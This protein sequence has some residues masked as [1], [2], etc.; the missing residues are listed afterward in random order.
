MNRR[1]FI[2]SS[3]TAATFFSGAVYSAATES[4]NLYNSFKTH[5]LIELRVKSFQESSQQD[6]WSYIQDF[7]I[8]DSNIYYNIED[9]V[10]QVF[11]HCKGFNYK[12]CEVK[13][14]I[15][16][17]NEKSGLTHAGHY[18][19]SDSNYIFNGKVERPYIYEGW[20]TTNP[21]SSKQFYK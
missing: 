2:K 9:A 4:L 19:F 7:W 15:L 10:S 21:S 6:E 12:K 3:A 13:Y 5:Y 1:N 14:D 11:E 17:A 18:H 8:N 16:Y 20:H